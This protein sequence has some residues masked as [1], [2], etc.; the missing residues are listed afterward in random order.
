VTDH[1]LEQR[2]QRIDPVPAPTS[3]DTPDSPRA[4]A[5]MEQ[6]MQTQAAPVEEPTSSRRRWVAA[7]AAVAGAA[8]AIAIGVAVV[9]NDATSSEPV[10]ATY[11]L[12]ASDPMAMCL[13]LTDAA[14]PPS[15]AIAFGGTVTEVTADKVVVDVDQTFAGG[16]VDVATLAA[17]PDVTDVALD[18]VE[19]VPGERY[20]VTVVD[21][22]VQTCGVSGP[23]SPELEAIY[24]GW[25]GA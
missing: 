14:P 8:A 21:G 9:R 22:R 17:G 7:A 19:F 23:A 10:A 6:I 5:I 18:G 1:E 25:F 20:L 12:Q 4:R 16:E 11:Q 24:A 2:L 15:G 13:A 3:V